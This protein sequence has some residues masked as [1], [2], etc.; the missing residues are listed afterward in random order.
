[1]LFLLYF[2]P[3]LP[4][5]ECLR[6]GIALH[7]KIGSAGRDAHARNRKKRIYYEIPEQASVPAMGF[8]I[9]QAVLPTRFLFLLMFREY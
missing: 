3:L 8:F 2:L 4:E 1:M 6:E 7:T 9:Q 5:P